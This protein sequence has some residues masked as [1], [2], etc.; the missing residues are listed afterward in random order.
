VLHHPGLL[1]L[2]PALFFQA[3]LLREGFRGGGG[4]EPQRQQQALRREAQGRINAVGSRVGPHT[5]RQAK[6]QRMSLKQL[7]RVLGAQQSMQLLAALFSWQRGMIDA[8]RDYAVMLEEQ[9]DTMEGMV[10]EAADVRY[11]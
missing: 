11:V 1:H 9:I 8:G 4:K 10:R 7:Q 2:S 3:A 6:L 5:E